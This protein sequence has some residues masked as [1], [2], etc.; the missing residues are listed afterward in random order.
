MKFYKTI[1][2]VLLAGIIF[3]ACSPAKAP[4]KYSMGE[5]ELGKG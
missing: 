4:V 3:A 2:I 1:F 5:K